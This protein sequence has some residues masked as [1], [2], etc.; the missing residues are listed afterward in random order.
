MKLDRR[1]KTLL[2][3]VMF[4]NVLFRVPAQRTGVRREMHAR[5]TYQMVQVRNAR[6]GKIVAVPKH[7][8][9]YFLSRRTNRWS[10]VA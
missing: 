2:G 7:N 9:D 3:L 8:V 10:V 1:L 4:G 6:T 5:K